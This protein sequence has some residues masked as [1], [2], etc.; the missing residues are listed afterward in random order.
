MNTSSQDSIISALMQRCAPEN[1]SWY[2]PYLRENIAAIMADVQ[3][4]NA[5][6][7]GFRGI[8]VKQE[9]IFQGVL[10]C[11]WFCLVCY[12]HTTGQTC[13][14]CGAHPAGHMPQ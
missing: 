14:Y 3:T 9:M 8:E 12:R 11:E 4:G 10:V 5:L 2:V 7:R 13:S 6:R 1:W